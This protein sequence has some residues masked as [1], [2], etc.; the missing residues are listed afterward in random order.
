[1]W[2]HEFVF[3]N[4]SFIQIA[5]MPLVSAGEILPAPELPSLCTVY[6]LDAVVAKIQVALDDLF[7]KSMVI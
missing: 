6:M 5:V 3:I 7:T 4:T 2:D 1:M